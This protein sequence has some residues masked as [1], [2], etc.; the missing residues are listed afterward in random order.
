[1]H[2]KYILVD[3]HTATCAHS[4]AVYSEGSCKGQAQSFYL[5]VGQEEV[6]GVKHCAEGWEWEATVKSQ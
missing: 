4:H 6:Y 3:Q 1:M 2:I 5:D